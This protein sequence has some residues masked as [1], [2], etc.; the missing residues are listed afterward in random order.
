M[1]VIC[2]FKNHPNERVMVRTL[3]KT[4]FDDF[5]YASKIQKVILISLPALEDRTILNSH[6]QQLYK[7]C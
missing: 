4:K 2:I 3:Q 1:I 7:G 6:A 5:G